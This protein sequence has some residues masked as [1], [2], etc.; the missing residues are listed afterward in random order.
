MNSAYNQ[1]DTLYKYISLY[2]HKVD[3]I[4]LDTVFKSSPSYPSLLS[5]YRS[6]NFYGM[7]PNV[8]RT[9]HENLYKL[10]RPCL[11]HIKHDSEFFLLIK[12]SNK[13]STIYYDPNKSRY[14][15]QNTDTLLAQWDGIVIYTEQ[16]EQPSMKKM[17]WILA[18]LITIVSCFHW[19]SFLLSINL[20][21]LILAF[22][23]LFHEYGIQTSIVE[24]V[25]KAGDSFDCNK[26]TQSKASR[27]IGIPLSVWGCLYFFSI[28]LFLLVSR[29]TG[30]TQAEVADYIRIICLGGLPILAYS[31]IKQT[32]LKVWCIL[33]LSIGTI[34]LSESVILI[35]WNNTFDYFITKQTVVLHLFSIAFA[36]IFISLLIKVLELH[37]KYVS[38]RMRYV[39]LKRKPAIIQQLFRNVK[40]LDKADDSYLS[41]GNSQASI[42]ITTWISPYCSHCEKLVKD[43]LK[44]HERHCENFEWR[45]YLS[46]NASGEREKNRVQHSLMTWYM[47]DKLLFL[48]ALTIWFNHKEL[49]PTKN[50]DIQFSDE[51]KHHLEKQIKFTEKMNISSYPKC[52]VNDL[53]LPSV[54]TIKDISYMIHD[55]E[56]WTCLNKSR[57]K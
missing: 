40:V 1:I 22:L 4:E 54:Y 57:L 56:I 16:E 44:L 13:I 14:T 3:K 10:N 31:V 41:L 26:V 42:V 35:L 37:K 46:G 51:I 27:I 12:C 30:V 2:K 33:C 20:W 47:K 25:C 9:K 5:I 55:E 21:G 8:V 38:L 23:L 29:C 53:E 52:F 7:Y 19:D 50:S 17:H 48:K 34:L 24:G 43:L 32:Q 15:K 39:T 49:V 28:I 11:L 36:G 18:I 6:L 45:I